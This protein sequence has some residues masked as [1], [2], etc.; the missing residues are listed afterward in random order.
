M[1]NLLLA[2]ACAALLAGPADATVTMDWVPVRN[3]G[4]APDTATNCLAGVGCGSVGY[5]YYISKYDVTNAQ[6][7][8][9][10]NAVDPTGSNTLA[11]YNTSMST[12]A[13][14]GGI[15]NTGSAGSVYQVKAGFAND[16]VVYVSF[17]DSLR[18]ANWLNNGQG[19]ASTET[20]AYTLLGGTPTPS[21][22]SV[23]RNADAMTFL[24]S[25]NEWY[26]AAY[27]N[28]VTNSYFA[29]PAGSNTP[30]VCAASGPTPNTANCIPNY[31]GGPG[32]G[33]VTPVGAY[34]GSASPYGM[35]DAGGNVLQWNE[36]FVG[37]GRGTRG[38]SW[39]YYGFY[40]AASYATAVTPT[41][42]HGDIGFR[43]ASLVP[44]PGTGLLVMTGLLG[45]AAQR[46]R[47]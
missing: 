22:T 37:S 14:N 43:V 16:P 30:T 3:P 6:Y 28:P 9:F 27:Y 15:T 21:N 12:D 35:F 20:G 45:L 38:G 40:L 8:E 13:S 33:H 32:V 39:N 4:N 23:M 34:T 10:L 42:E 11:L 44:E 2:G 47:A 36:Q 26:K 29:Y 41:L 17:Y 5:N 24:P 19:S 18:F 31:P 25:E 46:K 1:R 7:A